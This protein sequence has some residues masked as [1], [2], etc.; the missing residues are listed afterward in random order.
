MKQVY[1][2]TILLLLV[3]AA[4]TNK[5]EAQSNPIISNYIGST[6][7]PF[8]RVAKKLP[9]A[10][11]WISKETSSKEGQAR[12]P[13]QIDFSDVLLDKSFGTNGTVRT[14]VSGNDSMSCVAKSAV[15]QRDGKILVAGYAYSGSIHFFV[16]FRYLSDGTV[17]TTFGTDGFALTGFDNGVGNDVANSVALQADGKIIV[18]GSSSNNG[19]GSTFAVARYDTDGTLDTTFGTKGTVRTQVNGIYGNNDAGSAV[20]V[21][22]D[23]KIVVAGTSNGSFALAR[24]NSDGTLDNTFGSGGTVSSTYHG[25]DGTGDFGRSLVIQLDGKIVV[26]GSAYTFMDGGN[27]FAVARIDTD[28]VLDDT[29]AEFG[30]VKLPLFGYGPNAL[31]ESVALGSDGRLYVAGLFNNDDGQGNEFALYRL[32][33]DGSLDSTF[34]TDG[35]VGNKI[36]GGNAGDDEG[37]SVTVL[38]DGKVMIGGFS[39]STSGFA[40]AACRY[41]S[42]GVVDSTFG[43]SGSMRINIYG[44]SGADDEASSLIIQPDGKFVMAGYSVVDTSQLIAIARCDSNG[45]LDDSFN[46]TGT[47]KTATPGGFGDDRATGLAIQ[48]DGKIVVAGG[49]GQKFAVARYNSDGSLDSQFGNGGKAKVSISGGYGN[50]AGESVAI[51]SDGK[52]VV[53]GHTSNG[54]KGEFAVARFNPNGTLDNSFGTSGTAMAQINGSD[55][56]SDFAVSVAVQSDGKIVLGGYTHNSDG[57]EIALA[58]FNTDGTLDG[59]FGT[60]GTAK[61]SVNGGNGNDYAYSLAV[62]PGGKI[63]VAGQ[64]ILGSGA[65]FAVACFESTGTLDDS[66]GT[67]GTIKT[68]INGSDGTSDYVKSIGLLPDG[69]FVIV[70]IAHSSLGYRFAAARYNASGVP[71]ST[72]GNAGTVMLSKNGADSTDDFAISAAIQVDGKVLIGG[73]SQQGTLFS[74]AAARLNYDGSPDLTFCPAGVVRS[75]I[76]GG[77]G[78]VDLARSI[79]IQRNGK[80]IL[81]GSS[82]LSGHGDF[83]LL[84][85]L[86][87][88]TEFA[89]ALHASYVDTGSATFRGIVYPSNNP[90]QIKFLYGTKS[91]IYADSTIASPS[92]AFGDTTTLVEASLSGLPPSTTYYYRLSCLGSSS[93][94]LFVS[95][96]QSVRTLDPTPAPPL[97]IAPEGTSGVPRKTVLTWHSSMY[98]SRYTIQ[99]G[100]DS[101]FS[102]VDFDTLLTDTTFKLNNPLSATTKYYWHVNASDTS[103]TSPFSTA[104]SFITGIGLDAVEEADGIPKEYALY[105]NY[106]NPFNPSTMIRFDLKETSTVTLD[107]YNVLGQKVE[108]LRYGMLNPGTYEKS[109]SMF[110]F[111]SGVY[112]YRITAS[113]NDGGRFISVKKFELLK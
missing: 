98:A 3:V 30:S 93:G 70:G 9:G 6:R 54:S 96:E 37:M 42:T 34:G 23:G 15:I 1:H 106:P 72:F 102:S 5:S 74:F 36:D 49:S 59:G 57:Y 12:Y 58:R 91:N 73:F 61:A 77:L 46:Q 87:G 48:P 18:A 79:A 62:T 39:K 90:A 89:S 50:D 63:I 51:Q 56:T 25:S 14:E 105:Q 24:Y 40:F 100:R 103:G 97:L 20:A 110:R 78:T 113:R 53:A 26:A 67:N 104:G 107:I 76:G 88:S 55:G 47:T 44:G 112:F 52:I 33:A 21:Q 81:A 64:C 101:S 10:S 41:D 7:F 82:I 31:G 65:A 38:E 19:Q 83:A 92:T 80:I 108:E 86:P 85:Y 27:T 4:W 75:S 68:S 95:D 69:K 32:R 94:T 16:V 111:T 11:T 84:R 13:T 29:F 35:F 99:I 109:V 71:D 60:S 28:G 45:S 43:T 22:R 17:D 2:L 8:R 66:F